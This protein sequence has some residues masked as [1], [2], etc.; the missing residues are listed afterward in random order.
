MNHVELILKIK[1]IH[2]NLCFEMKVN[3]KLMR[4]WVHIRRKHS[5]FSNTK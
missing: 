5:A 4:L 2:F 3:L 1:N